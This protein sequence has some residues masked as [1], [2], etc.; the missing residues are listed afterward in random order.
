ML[1]GPREGLPAP[2]FV[3]RALIQAFDV[4]GHLPGA[5]PT[6]VNAI[7]CVLSRSLW[8]G[9]VEPH[10][11]RQFRPEHRPWGYPVLRQPPV[12]TP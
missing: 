3:H 4:P 8:P 5:C 12:G 6:A 7:R 11:S 2:S 9:G 1:W 10:V